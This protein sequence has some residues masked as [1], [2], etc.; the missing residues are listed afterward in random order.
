LG[1]LVLWQTL[2]ESSTQIEIIDVR[3]ESKSIWSA[4]HRPDLDREVGQIHIGEGK[5]DNP[6]QEMSEL[7]RDAVA[8]AWQRVDIARLDEGEEVLALSEPEP[9][10]CFGE[11]KVDVDEV[12]DGR[13]VDGPEMVPWDE[14]PV[15]TAVV[16]HNGG[17]DYPA[18]ESLA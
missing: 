5:I 16:Q 8:V 12:R 6:E 11:A 2:S 1:L 13:R 10:L 14:R 4:K 9:V 17:L 7:K 18:G 3:E 15:V